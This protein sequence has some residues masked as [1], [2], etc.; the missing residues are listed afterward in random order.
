MTTNVLK[1]NANLS[2]QLAMDFNEANDLFGKETLNSMQ[3]VQVNGGIVTPIP[4][5]PISIV[6]QLIEIVLEGFIIFSGSGSGS[7][8]EFQGDG[9]GKVKF[10]VPSGMTFSADSIISAKTPVGNELKI[11]GVKVE[12]SQSGN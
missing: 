10:I 5:G 4:I 8:V 1:R 7:D 9:N 11:Y 6:L 2:N 3:M 12:P